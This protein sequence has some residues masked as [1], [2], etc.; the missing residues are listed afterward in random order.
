MFTDVVG[1]TERAAYLGDRRWSSRILSAAC[2][3]TSALRALTA[4]GG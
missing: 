1:S 4:V 2:W 3:L